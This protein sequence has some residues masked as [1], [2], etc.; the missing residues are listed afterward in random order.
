MWP[1]IVIF[2][3][4][5]KATNSRLIVMIVFYFQKESG[6]GILMSIR[7][8]CQRGVVG[9]LSIFCINW[10]GF[11]I[12]ILHGM[13]VKMLYLWTPCRI[14]IHDTV[15]TTLFTTEV[16]PLRISNA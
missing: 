6:V 4:S 5:L 14:F 11:Y 9:T 16:K 15:D 12:G 2:V 13:N 8:G 3:N 10:K 1:T 7:D